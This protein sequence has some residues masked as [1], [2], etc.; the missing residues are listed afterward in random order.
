MA[1]SISGTKWVCSGTFSLL[2]GDSTDDNVKDIFDFAAFVT[3]R[4]ASKTPLSRSNFN[5]DAVVNNADFG[6]ISLNFL[7]TGDTCNGGFF[8]GGARDR[9]SVKELRRMGLGYME[10]ADIDGDGWVDTN[11]IALAAQGQYRRPIEGLDQPAE[12]EQPN[13]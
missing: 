12:L 13:W 2:A 4:G 1:M 9:V 6:Y 3:D 8:N 5:R 7:A 11:D 10:E